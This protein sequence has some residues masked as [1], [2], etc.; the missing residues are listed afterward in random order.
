M[1]FDSLHNVLDVFL[2]AEVHHD[3]SLVKNCISQG[4]EVKV[5]ALHMV[6]NAAG[7]SNKNIDSASEFA[8]LCPNVNASIYAK[9]IV[10]FRMMLQGV[11]LL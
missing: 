3:V 8:G 6:L 9:Y 5:F 10:F 11:K 7:G 4:T 2:E 1:G